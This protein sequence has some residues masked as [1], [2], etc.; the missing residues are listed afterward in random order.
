MKLCMAVNPEINT[1]RIPINPSKLEE[2]SRGKPGKPSD[3]F[4][5]VKIE[6][7]RD[8]LFN[9]AKK[10]DRCSRLENYYLLIS[11]DQHNLRL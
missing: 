6:G 7:L 1:Q 2:G 11:E 4:H 8:C 3:S 9:H 10:R 5:R